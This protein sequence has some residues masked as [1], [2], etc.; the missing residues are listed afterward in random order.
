[1]ATWFPIALAFVSVEIIAVTIEAGVAAI[2]AR[3]AKD[4]A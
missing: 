1:V 3:S 4:C 2:R